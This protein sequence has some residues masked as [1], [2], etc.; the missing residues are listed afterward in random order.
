MKRCGIPFRLV[1]QDLVAT[2][3][4]RRIRA[5]IAEVCGVTP[6]RPR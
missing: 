2:W 1:R 5:E 3:I 4:A 6:R